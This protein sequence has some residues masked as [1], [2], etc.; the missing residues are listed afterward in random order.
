VWPFLV[1]VACVLATSGCGREVTLMDR[2]ADSTATSQDSLVM[3]MRQAADAWEGGG[4]DGA[5]AR[6]TARALR[7]ELGRHELDE[8][9]RRAKYLLDSLGVG[10]EMGGEPCGLL[11][12]LFPRSDP[13]RG[14]W[15]F[16]FWCPDGLKS[17]QVPNVEELEGRG[18][19]LLATRFRR[20]E[21][22][23]PAGAKSGDQVAAL[24]GRTR[25]SRQEP[26]LYLWSRT[27]K[28]WNIVQ[29]LGAD[30]LG[31]FGDGRFESDAVPVEL[32]VRTYQPRRGF[33]ECVA[34]PHVWFT[35]RFRWT[36]SGF[37]RVD[38]Q[39]EFSTY[40]TL[41]RFV[42]AMENRDVDPALFATGSAI[43][44]LA[45][46]FEWDVRKGTWRVA[47]GSETTG[48][49]L[50]VFRGQQESYRVLFEP[51]S[52]DWLVSGIESVPRSI[53]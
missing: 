4:D 8:W 14:S 9:P 44:E 11:L 50:L 10:V 29:T 43:V 22:A 20:A 16:L 3:V 35:H 52:G 1:A 40:V 23:D 42:E 49:E 17:P 13:G 25:G 34:C 2:G 51:R 6:L 15:P 12:N 24:F 48:R 18:M 38:S 33:D 19:R 39:Q 27:D 31:G 53:E 47:P 21:S 26:I 5:A 7:M 41:V 32:A 45:R 36:D 28:R 30:S 37:E 46:S